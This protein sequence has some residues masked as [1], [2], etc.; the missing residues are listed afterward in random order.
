MR[1]K[2]KK[3]KQTKL[4][5]LAKNE[6]TW[7]ELSKKLG[8]NKHYLEIE[9]KNEK[10][11]LSE[12]LY[13]NLCKIARV[14]YEDYIEKK[15]DS[16]WGRA[17]G[18]KNSAKPPRLLVSTYSEKLAE[19]IGI[20]LGDGNVWVKKHNYSLTIAGDK[21]KDKNYLINYVKPLL[22]EIF[23]QK[24]FIKYSK[25]NNT[26][27]LTKGSKDIV[28]TLSYFGI[29]SGNK[30]KN[31]VKIPEWILKNKR[32]T[33]SCIRGLIDT[34]GSVCPITGRNYSYIW[35]TSNIEN[36]RKTFDIAM[37]NLGIKTSKWNT[38]K[39]RSPELF[40]GGK[41]QINKYLK[42][43]SFKNQKHLSKLSA[44]VV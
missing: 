24:I 32:Y 34:D 29:S 13:N 23:K 27:Y 35:F 9:L 26:L 30:Q 3:T 19:I 43:I 21:N 33:R 22:E 1:I 5:L 39:N 28:Y 42:E 36:L 7:K 17:K 6:G 38:R 20:I 12:K 37:K 4:I 18:G 31:N 11:T 2:L 8:I 14:N 40:I 15:L 10:R 16:N 41:D 25:S 44:P